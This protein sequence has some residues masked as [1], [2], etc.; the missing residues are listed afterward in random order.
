MA[1][2][3]AAYTCAG[4]GPELEAVWSPESESGGLPVWKEKRKGRGGLRQSS[5]A[6]GFILVFS[7]HC[8][9]GECG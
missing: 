5:Q 4:G 7:M 1:R 8:Q 3:P 2:S 9:D 6:R